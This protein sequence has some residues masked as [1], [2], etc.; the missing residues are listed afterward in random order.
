MAPME[1]RGT[2]I[3]YSA[4]ADQL[5]DDA[6]NA[7]NG[8]F[9]GKLVEALEEPGLTAAELFR[10]VRREVYTESNGD[11]WPAVYDD[12]LSDF[13]FRP[14]APDDAA[15]AAELLQQETTFWTSI[16]ESTNLEDFRAYLARYPDGAYVALARN[17]AVALEKENIFW[18]GIVES[19][20]LED[21][22]GVSRAVPRRRLRSV[23]KE[24]GG[25][26]A[27]GSKRSG[28]GVAVALGFASPGNE[29]VERA[30]GGN[31]PALG[32]TS[33]DIEAVERA[34]G[35]GFSASSF[36]SPS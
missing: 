31:V 19:T 29:T 9:T 7:A 18:T 12:L 4:G 28:T 27:R 35:S 23:G 16:V 15:V 34:D 33:P 11:Q 25:G 6:P 17:R 21:F 3:A 8:L 22:R 5:A 30:G 1:A 10:R 24:S 14:G 20:N 13:V 2:L 32:F 26:P 36:T